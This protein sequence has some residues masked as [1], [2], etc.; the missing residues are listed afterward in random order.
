MELVGEEKRIQALFCELAL[1]DQSQAPHFE[2]L[3]QRAEAKAVFSTVR[4]SKWPLLNVPLG[5]WPLPTALNIRSRNPRLLLAVTTTVVILTALVLLAMWARSPED[6][7]PQQRLAA[8]LSTQKTTQSRQLVVFTPSKPHKLASRRPARARTKDAIVQKA[9]I[10]SSW[11][12]PTALFMESPADPL[13]KSLPQLNQSV[14]E[15]ES[16]LPNK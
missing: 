13:L 16:F 12:S 14:K 6:L 7:A 9:T 15:M 10:I 5:H 8:D 3:W 4:G 2:K 1:E 11:R